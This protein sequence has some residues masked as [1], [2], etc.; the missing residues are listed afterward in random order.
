MDLKSPWSILSSTLWAASVHSSLTTNCSLYIYGFKESLK[1]FVEHIMS[2][3]HILFIVN[4][5]QA[6]IHISI[7]SPQDPDSWIFPWCRFSRVA[8]IKRKIQV[9]RLKKLQI[10]EASKKR[11]WEMW[12]LIEQKLQVLQDALRRERR[13]V[14]EASHSLVL[15]SKSAC[16]S[17]KLF[18]FSCFAEES[19]ME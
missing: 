13:K 12:K 3:L 15:V 14:D 4:N 16:S 5:R 18:A 6:P 10:E 7:F 1:H 8:E 2:S 17:C 19:D 9:C 11:K